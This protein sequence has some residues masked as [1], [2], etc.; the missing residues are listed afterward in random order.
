[1]SYEYFL[2]KIYQWILF[3]CSFTEIL[4]NKFKIY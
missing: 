3:D 4:S 1:M 2:Q